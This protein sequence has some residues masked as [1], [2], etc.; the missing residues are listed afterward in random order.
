MISVHSFNIY[1]YNNKF[2][3]SPAFTFEHPTK[4]K[5]QI[6]ELFYAKFVMQGLTNN[7]AWNIILHLCCAQV[8]IRNSWLRN[9]R[10][11]NI[12]AQNSSTVFSHDETK[13]LNV[14]KIVMPEM[15]RICRI[16]AS[17][18]KRSLRYWSFVSVTPR[19]LFKW[20]FQRVQR[21]SLKATC[22]SR[23]KFFYSNS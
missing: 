19:C 16:I 7:A 23:L 13:Y 14:P 20:N 12:T 15:Q 11:W 18:C 6:T 3:L 5:L 22:D 8:F 4:R 21:I 9:E 17:I 10:L 2:L 1:Q